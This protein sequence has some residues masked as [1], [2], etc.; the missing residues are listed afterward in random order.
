M[1]ID[2]AKKRQVIKA[3]NNPYDE[4]SANDTSN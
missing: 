2:E 3:T 4:I 1:K